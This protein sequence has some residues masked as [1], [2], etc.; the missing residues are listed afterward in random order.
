[1]CDPN[2]CG[3]VEMAC[4]V[5]DW[6]TSQ[7]KQIGELWY[8]SLHTLKAAGRSEKEIKLLQMK[9]DDEF[10]DFKHRMALRIRVV[11]GQTKTAQNAESNEATTTGE[12]YDDSSENTGYKLTRVFRDKDEWRAR[13]AALRAAL[14]TDMVGLLTTP[15][16]DPIEEL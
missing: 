3:A 1:E 16:Y 2:T 15:G 4:P 13:N 14:T 6:A 7:L 10:R 8:K 5:G 11:W 12:Q 9:N